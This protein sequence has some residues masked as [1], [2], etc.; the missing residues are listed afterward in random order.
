[1]KT[2]RKILGFILRSIGYYFLFLFYSCMA[3][4][5]IRFFS[6]G[7][8]FSR[9][10]SYNTFD[11][12]SEI[13]FD[14]RF[15]FSIYSPI[16]FCFFCFDALWHIAVLFSFFGFCNPINSHFMENAPFSVCV[17]VF[18]LSFPYLTAAFSWFFHKYQISPPGPQSIER[19]SGFWSL[20]FP[21]F[22]K[23]PEDDLPLTED[24]LRIEE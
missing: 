23:T 7:G 2:L 8:S 1:M 5:W 14:Q 17:L 21:Q 10:H 11:W 3:F 9:R 22:R 24:D 18:S 19:L 16:I 12:F 15:S 13:F 4:N 6:R 20:P